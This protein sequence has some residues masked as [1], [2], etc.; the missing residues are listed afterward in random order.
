[1]IIE[2]Q[3]SDC[4]LNKRD[5]RPQIY[6][7]QRTAPTPPYWLNPLPTLNPRNVAPF[8]PESQSRRPQRHRHVRIL[9]PTRTHRRKL[10][11]L[12]GHQQ[13]PSLLATRLRGW[14]VCCV[15]Y[16]PFYLRRVEVWRVSCVAYEQ[17][18]TRDKDF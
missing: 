14:I 17:A 4:A 16:W 8:A 7:H 2:S 18:W 13:P 11:F 3:S 1:M 5:I 15:A 12:H 10:R 6:H 9:E